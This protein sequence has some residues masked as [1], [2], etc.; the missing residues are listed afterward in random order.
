M[1]AGWKAHAG[2]LPARDGARLAVAGG[3]DPPAAGPQRARAG[4]RP[5][6]HRAAGRASS[7]RPA[8]ACSSPTAP[9]RWSRPRASTPRRSARRTSNYGPC[10]PSGSTCR[11]RRVD[12]VLCRFGL[13]AARRPR[14][15]AARDAARAAARRARRAR[16]VGR[17]RAQ[18]VDR[19]S[20][21]GDGGARPDRAA[22]RRRAGPARAR[23]PR[24]RSRSCSTRPGSTTSRSS[25]WTSPSTPRA[26]TSGGSTRSRCR[27]R[28]ALV[29]GLGPAEHYAC[30][31][32]STPGT[33]RTCATTDRSKSRA[34]AGGG[35][36]RVARA[37]PCAPRPPGH[38]RLLLG[39][40]DRRRRPG[41]DLLPRALARPGGAGARRARGAA[42]LQHAGRRST[43]PTASTAS[44]PTPC[45]RDIRQLV[46]GTRD[47]SPAAARHRAGHDA[48]DDV[49]RH[50]RHRALRVAHPRLRRATTSSPGACATWRSARASRSWS[51]RRAP[52]RPSSATWPTRSNLRAHAAGRRCCVVVN[53]RRLDHRLRRCST[54]GRRARDPTGARACS[55]R[56]RPASRSRPCPRSWA[57]TSARGAG[58]AAVRLFLLLAVI[59]AGLYVIDRRLG[60]PDAC[61]A[62]AHRGREPCARCRVSRSRS[63]RSARTSQDPP[64]MY[65]D[66]DADLT[67][68]DGKTVAIIGFGSQGH[69][70]ALNLKDS[71]RRRRRRP[72]RG[73]LERRAGARGRA[74]GAA[75]SPTPPRAATS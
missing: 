14:G 66:D 1:A 12:A 74:R 19:R 58:F 25:R 30:V 60:R 51:S 40:G 47:N 32:R 20:S 21:R 68:L 42:A 28:S 63:R 59:I 61:V 39:H 73:L 52:A 71:G 7:S 34:G 31:T 35:G 2:Q 54:T 70:H 15:G 3:G 43:S 6:R 18:P 37:C 27:G 50:R 67:L 64:P 4:R 65:Y 9:R 23:P 5:R 17:P 56:C 75:A 26:S 33:P 29:G 10:R 16:G 44:C 22:A 72:A 36:S 38:I 13:H 24:R 55:A 57:S 53:T 48:V 41:A 46:L 8:G 49:G 45:T 69:A 62:G 11:R